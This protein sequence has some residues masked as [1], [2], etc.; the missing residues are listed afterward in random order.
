MNR[1]KPTWKHDCSSCTFLGVYNH[2]DL[3][4]CSQEAIPTV[5]ARFGARSKYVSGAPIARVVSMKDHNQDP[6][7]KALRVA[8]L[9]AVD[10][11][12]I[13]GALGTGR[14]QEAG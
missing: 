2:H 10:M 12:L 5:I 9:I 6:S 1:I 3:Y 8:Y 4:F 11:G 13:G 14:A 7:L